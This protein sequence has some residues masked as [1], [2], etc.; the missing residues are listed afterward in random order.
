[1]FVFFIFDFLFLF[2]PSLSPRDEKSVLAFHQSLQEMGGE[3]P[4]KFC[5]VVRTQGM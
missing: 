2:W 3:I 5:V 4:E 1:M